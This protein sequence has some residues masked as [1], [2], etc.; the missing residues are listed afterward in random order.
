MLHT[1]IGA[2]LEQP[3]QHSASSYSNTALDTIISIRLGF[4]H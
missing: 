1:I 4:G 3:R 2:N